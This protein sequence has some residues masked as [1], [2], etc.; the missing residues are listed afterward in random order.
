MRGYVTLTL[1]FTILSLAYA[2][3]A[4]LTRVECL[5]FDKAFATIPKCYLKALSRYRSAF[6]LHVALHQVPVTNVSF[7]AAFFRKGNNGYRLFMYNNTVDFCSFYKNPNRF[8]FWKIVF[9][10][11]IAPSSNINHTCPF[12]HDIIVEKLILDSEMFKMIPFPADEYMAKVKVAAY[13]H[14][15]AEIKA[16]L[17]ISE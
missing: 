11:I 12:D 5:E 9:F 4:K 14:F 13:N 10:N 2:L 15:K 6:S 1:T 16:Y 7:N 17:Q 3:K 8:I